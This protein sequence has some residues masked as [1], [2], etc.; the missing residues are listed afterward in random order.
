MQIVWQP[1]E[2]KAKPSGKRPF[3]AGGLRLV[4]NAGLRLA[5]HAG[6][7]F[8][9]EGG[10]S[11]VAADDAIDTLSPAAAA[12]KAET[13]LTGAHSNFRLTDSPTN[14]SPQRLS[15]SPPEA[16]A[17]HALGNQSSDALSNQS[18]PAEKIEM[19]VAGAIV[20]C[21]IIGLIIVA[22]IV[23]NLLVCIAIATDRSLKQVS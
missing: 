12:A 15:F 10:F 4:T 18:A 14:D 20:T 17:I 19:N 23:G 7:L 22:T 16:L 5:T 21:V 8:A 6:I 9:T 13:A 1:G 2:T 11:L 3:F